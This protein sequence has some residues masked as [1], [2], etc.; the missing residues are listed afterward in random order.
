MHLKTLVLDLESK[1]FGNR[2]AIPFHERGI[3]VLYVVA[4]RTDDLRLEALGLTVEGVEL[5]VLANVDLADDSAFYEKGKASVEGS[6]RD[7]FLEF[8]SIFEQ[9][10]GCE[11]TGLSK[12][13]L[14]YSFS[15]VGHA[16]ALA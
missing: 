3:Y 16:Q 10:L 12:E 6:S 8:L 14:D 9:F 1:F 4:V 13:S 11:V 5:V 2:F 7:G 15:L